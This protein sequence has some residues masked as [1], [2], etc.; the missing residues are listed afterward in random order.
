MTFLDVG[1]NIGYFTLLA[2]MYIRD[3][4]DDVAATLKERRDRGQVAVGLRRGRARQ[5]RGPTDE[6]ANHRPTQGA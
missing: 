3:V 4:S 6:R 2:A 1:A 5:D